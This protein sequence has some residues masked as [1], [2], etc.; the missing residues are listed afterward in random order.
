M[1]FHMTEHGF[2]TETEF[3]TLHVSSDEEKGFR[4]YQLM[5]ASIAGCGGGVMRKILDRMRAPA[6]DIIVEVKEVE[7]SDD[8]VSR[9]TKVHLHFKVIGS[10]ITEAK[11]PRIMELTE[12]NCSMLQSVNETMDI[13]KTY[14]LIEK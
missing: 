12:K 8:E 7:R 5:I 3:G 10:T 14:E 6:K 2:D 4:P 9:L 11:M 13:V 1:K